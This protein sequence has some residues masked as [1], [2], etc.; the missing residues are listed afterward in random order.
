MAY[1]MLR[2]K[3]VSRNDTKNS[4]EQAALAFIREDCEGLRFDAHKAT[5]IRDGNLDFE[6]T[7]LK[8]NQIPYN[9]EKDI[10]R[11]CLEN[12][13]D[14]FLKSGRKEDAFDVY[15]CYLEMF[16]GDYEKTRRMIELLSEFEANGSGLLMKHRDHYS[17][18]VYVFTLGLAI[19]ESNAFFQETY[20]KFYGLKD[21]QKA[22]CH[23]LQYWGLASLFHDI[24]Y[25][26]ELPFEQVASYFEVD[27]DKREERPFVAYHGLDS[28]IAIDEEVR[29]SLKEVISGRDFADT[30]ELYAYLLADRLA[31]TYGFTE[32]Q[33]LE[34]LTEKPT[35]PDKFNHYM[36]H[37]Y[38]SA[39]VLFKKLFGE[40]K[41][42]LNR[43][44]LDAL[45]AI[46][47]HNSL[48][49][50]CIAHYKSERNIRF[51]AKFHP[52]AFML[53]LCDE[54]QCWD[55]TAYGRNSKKELHPMGCIFDFSDNKVK[56]VYLFDEKEMAKINGFK[57]AY[58]EW[59]QER[60]QE[61][62]PALKA[63]SAMYIRQKGM[64]GFQ[65]DI[66]RIVDLTEMKLTVE[67]GLAANSRGA[68]R[69]YLS[70][71][72]FINLYNFAVILNG[73]WDNAQWKQAKKAGQ[74]EKF[75]ADEEAM[76]KFLESFKGLSLEYKLYNINQAKAFAGHMAKIGCFYTDKPVDFELVEGFSAEDLVKIGVLEHQRWL[77]DHYAMGWIYGTPKKEERDFLRQH[78]DMVPEFG[79]GQANVSAEV[80]KEN[81]ER[82]DQAEQNKDTEPMEC[83]LA[84]L[85]MFDGIRIYRLYES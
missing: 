12:A 19:Y 2:N 5:D 78:K 18:S 41:C 51:Q 79:E 42:T 50:F 56:A 1:T 80:A 35:R 34:Y 16:V 44:S 60:P 26:F 55:R 22:A 66:E 47:M 39:S 52:L 85:K 68:D 77:Q 8:A 24:G 57:D 46:L 36:D 21:R 74:E 32:S 7:S 63:Y 9:M 49:K 71:S 27:G 64:S 82:L 69:G 10:D 62:A 70:D 15:F 54:L 59:L 23:F 20:R 13:V 83:M 75:L 37:A 58:I 61:K 72:N 73:R 4:L 40:M 38:F 76:E 14:R 25:P 17:H 43:E 29:A 30:N 53:M 31:A 33:M 65:E 67:T 28:F 3:V 81:Y 48:Y 84:M 45:T 11:L 6:G